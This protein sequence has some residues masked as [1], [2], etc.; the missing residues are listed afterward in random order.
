MRKLLLMLSGV[1]G[2]LPALAQ[3]FTYEYEGQTLNYYVISETDRT[4]KVASGNTS[5]TGSVSIP[6]SV[7]YNDV[8]YTVTTIGEYAFSGCNGL[9]AIEISNSVTTI[10]V[11]AFSDCGSLTSIT[12]PEGLTSLESSVFAHS[13]LSEVILPESLKSIGDCCFIGCPLTGVKFGANIERIGSDAFSTLSQ[14][15]VNENLVSLGDKAF[16]D[17]LR[18][19][20][21]NRNTPPQLASVNMGYSEDEAYNILVIVP[22]NSDD[23]YKNDR[24]WEGFHIV[25]TA[26]T[27]TVYMTGKYPLSEEIAT[28]TQ[29]MPGAVTSLAIVGQLADGDWNIIKR[30]LVSC[31]DLDL[32]GVTN[33]EIP[34]ETFAENKH[35][36]SLKL[37]AKLKTVGTKAFYG[38]SNLTMSELPASIETIG[39]SAFEGCTLFDVDALPASLK[40]IEANA[41]AYCSRL[42]ITALPAIKSIGGGAF[43][44]CPRIMELDMSA[45]RFTVIES[46][47]FADCTKLRNIILPETVRTIEG[48]GL[49]DYPGHYSGGAFQNTSINF[50]ALPESLKEIGENVFRNTPIISAELPRQITDLGKGSFAECSKIKS[51][52]FSAQIANIGEEAFLNCRGIKSISMPSAL[53]PTVSDNAFTNV[54]YRDVVV[55]IPTMNYRDY[56]NAPGWGAFTQL[57]NSIFLEYE[58]VDE[59]GNDIT[60]AE[61]DQENVKIGAIENGTYSEIVDNIMVEVEQAAADKALDEALYSNEPMTRV[62]IAARVKRARAAARAAAETTAD[63]QARQAFTRLYPGLSMT[64]GDNSGYRVKIEPQNGAEIVKIE[65]G[66]KDITDTYVDGMVTLPTLYSRSNLKVYRKAVKTGIADITADDRAATADV[67]NMQGIAVLRNATEAQVRSLSHGLYIYKGRKI[68]I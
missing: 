19:L 12:L 28:T 31:Y 4:C 52:S 36:L 49:Y 15:E 60:E 22:T 8:E 63:D 20:K 66:G 35:I 62:E 57:A 37:P 51:V 1:L 33:T 30:N 29:Q 42:Q 54:R 27:K 68:A 16:G 25:E 48:G 58:E 38:C 47:T 41:F 67:Y 14:F 23:A 59:N 9:N 17:N 32:S 39:E 61:A 50:V 26:P 45:A 56:L 65:F 11:C 10:G 64:I 43:Y 2:A 18:M 3:D 46:G 7:V 5:L 53:P 13:R 21:M 55:A 24:N 34:A 6:S 44:S 40:T